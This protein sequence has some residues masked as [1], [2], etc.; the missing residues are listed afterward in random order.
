MLCVAM[1]KR[2]KKIINL[3]TLIVGVVVIHFLGKLYA[4]RM[5]AELKV[6]PSPDLYANDFGFQ[7]VA[8]WYIFGAGLLVVLL[9]GIFILNKL[10]SRH[11][12]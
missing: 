4:S 3:S 1:N 7:Y 12:K 5:M 8:F 2:T 11:V 6:N 9:V 10:L